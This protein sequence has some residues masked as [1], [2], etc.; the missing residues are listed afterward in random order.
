MKTK[1]V[2]KKLQIWAP[3]QTNEIWTI[4]NDAHITF[5]SKN[6]EKHKL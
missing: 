5:Y 6:N 3:E 4:Q 1:Q 2:R